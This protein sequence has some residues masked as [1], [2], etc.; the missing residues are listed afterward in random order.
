MPLEIERKFLVN[1]NFKKFASS[2]INIIQGYL[3]L[4]PERAVRIRIQGE[5]AFITI[6][7]IGNA[8]GA[9]R[10]EWE[11]EIPVAEAGELI[12]LCEPGIIEKERYEVKAGNHIFEVDE[13]FG[14]N[15]GLVIAEVELNDENELFDKP[16][17][18]GEEV[19]GNEKYYNLMLMKM[20]FKSWLK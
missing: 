1:G 6:K 16:E 10:Y 4:A 20:P 9:S 2:K 5:K 3:S 13:F 8:T 14:E 7:G 19:T 12:K 15:A 17:W 18:L 11:K